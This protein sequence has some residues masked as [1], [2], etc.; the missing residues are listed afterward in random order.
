MGWIGRHTGDFE[1][2]TKALFVHIAHYITTAKIRG[3]AQI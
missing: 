2:L 1:M 3:G